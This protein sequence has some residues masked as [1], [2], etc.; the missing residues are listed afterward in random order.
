MVPIL[1]AVAGYA[2]LLGL[3][4]LVGEKGRRIVRAILVELTILLVIWGI[5]GS[6][7]GPQRAYA[8]PDRVDFHLDYRTLLDNHS[9]PLRLFLRDTLENETQKIKETPE[10]GKCGFTRFLAGFIL[11]RLK[12]K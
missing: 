4:A 5:G 6:G 3:V 8:V 2:L 1:L 11:G 7:Y 12:R 10:R 9:Y